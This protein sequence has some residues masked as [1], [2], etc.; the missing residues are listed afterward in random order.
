MGVAKRL[1]AFD[2]LCRARARVTERVLSF[3]WSL[4]S[5]NGG[6]QKCNSLRQSLRSL[7]GGGQIGN[8]AFNSLCGAQTG[9]AKRTIAFDSLSNRGSQMCFDNLCGA[10]TGLENVY[11]PSTGLD[12]LTSDVYGVFV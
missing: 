4:W 1:L 5:L 10:R 12:I 8:I 6:C 3:I 2:S 9:V 11:Q 7:N